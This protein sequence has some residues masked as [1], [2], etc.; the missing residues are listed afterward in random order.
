MKLNILRL[1][2]NTICNIMRYNNYFK[3]EIFIFVKGA[4]E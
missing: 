4:L 3:F 1:T 2:L